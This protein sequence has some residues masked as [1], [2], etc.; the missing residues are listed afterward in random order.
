[1]NA[2]QI[3]DVIAKGF[4]LIEALRQATE[5]ATPAIKALY[6]LIEKQKSG[7]IITEV[8]LARVEAILDAQLDA[9]NTP[10]PAS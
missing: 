9:F 7:A 2:Q 4:T 8:D 10:L 6:D 1:M 5:A 3:L